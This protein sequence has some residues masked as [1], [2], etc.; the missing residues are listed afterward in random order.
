MNIDR[1]FLTRNS[2]GL[3]RLRRVADSITD[4]E[5]ALTVENG[6]TVAASFAHLAFWDRQRRELLRYWEAGGTEECV[7]PGDVFN[8]ALLPLL[9]AVP[10]RLAVRLAVQEAEAI[11]DY[12][13]SLPVASIA[14]V[15]ARPHPPNL[16]RSFHWEHHLDQIELACARARQSSS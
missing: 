11:T 2:A 15:L 12:L 7:Y 14:A 10:S 4:A 3:V 9:L 8:A 16:E 6:W 13:A 5:L 1:S